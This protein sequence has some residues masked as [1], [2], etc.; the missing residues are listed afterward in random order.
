[1][2]DMDGSVAIKILRL[3]GYDGLVVGLTG[4]AMDEDLNAFCAA[5]V[6]YALPKPFVIDD[7][8]HILKC[9]FDS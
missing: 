9:N 5:G 1:M 8:V 3:A 7:F 6:D 2:T 4:S